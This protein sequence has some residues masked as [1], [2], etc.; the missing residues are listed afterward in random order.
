MA[1]KSTYIRQIGI[2]VYLAHIGCFVNWEKA[3]IWIIDGI[4][5]RIG[6][7]DHQI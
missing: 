3:N 4:Y 7:S 1:G 2:A 5:S 6:S